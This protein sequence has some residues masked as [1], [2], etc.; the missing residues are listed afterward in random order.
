MISDLL[1]GFGVSFLPG[2][3]HSSS[4]LWSLPLVGGVG[5]VPCESLLVG[6]MCGVFWCMEPGLVSLK[7]SAISSH[8]FWVSVPW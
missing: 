8:V 4:Q 6:G 7:G 2:G 3:S 1:T 5:S